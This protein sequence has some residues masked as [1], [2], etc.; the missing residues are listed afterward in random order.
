[1]TAQAPNVVISSASYSADEQ[2]TG[3]RWIGGKP[4]YKR[5]FVRANLAFAD[6]AAILF[7][8]FSEATSWIDKIVKH[9]MTF[10]RA[11]ANDNAFTGITNLKLLYARHFS[12]VTGWGIYVAV[13]EAS[14]AADRHLTLYYTKVAD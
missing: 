13:H 7:V 10:Q 1:M 3:E 2:R 5:T 4:I 6:D 9:E 12:S 8:G 11:I 14:D